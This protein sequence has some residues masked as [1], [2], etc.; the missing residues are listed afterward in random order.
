MSQITQEIL[1]NLKSKLTNEE[2]DELKREFNVTEP[3]KRSKWMHMWR[4]SPVT[5]RVN[6]GLFRAAK[7]K[8]K[9]RV[10]LQS[11]EYRKFVQELELILTVAEVD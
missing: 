10:V 6:L 9:K 7:N 2:L 4:V 1:D 3:A 5:G 11:E 8:L